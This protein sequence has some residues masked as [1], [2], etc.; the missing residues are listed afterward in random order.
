[1]LREIDR[2]STVEAALR[3]S[4]DPGPVRFHLVPAPGGAIDVMTATPAGESLAYTVPPE[5]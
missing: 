4:Y 5:T 1:V 3:A 2:E